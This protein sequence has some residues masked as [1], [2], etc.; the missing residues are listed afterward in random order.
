MLQIDARAQIFFNLRFSTHAEQAL[1]ALPHRDSNH[2]PNRALGLTAEPPGK[3]RSS[4]GFSGFSTVKSHPNFRCYRQTLPVPSPAPKQPRRAWLGGTNPGPRGHRGGPTA[5]PRDPSPRE[6]CGGGCCVSACLSA[7]PRRAALPPS[8]SSQPCDRTIRKVHTS[9]AWQLGR[10]RA[11]ST[12][13][14]TL[15]YPHIIINTGPQ[16]GTGHV[17]Q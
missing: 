2:R 8:P 6:E 17:P 14:Y 3:L 11:T 16:S 9:H 13:S 10:A 1:F 12:I 5:S 7:H 15:L 4:S